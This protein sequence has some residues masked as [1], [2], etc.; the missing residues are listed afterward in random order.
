LINQC[1]YVFGFPTIEELKE[2]LLPNNLFR[3]IVE[4]AM[5]AIEAMDKMSIVMVEKEYIHLC[6]V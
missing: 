4:L 1:N 5:N 2:D 6:L 3:L